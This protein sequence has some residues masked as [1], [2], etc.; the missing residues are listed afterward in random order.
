MTKFIELLNSV[1]NNKYTTI[2]GAGAIAYGVYEIL[3]EEGD[4]QWGIV[5][6]IMGT[7]FLFSKDSDK[8]TKEEVE[9][10]L[11][12]KY[13]YPKNGNMEFRYEE[14]SYFNNHYPNDYPHND[15]EF[16]QF[17]EDNHRPTK[18]KNF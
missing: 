6:I 8:D 11:N 1:K 10:S 2:I 16:E 12:T 18:N 3:T 17:Y 14:P 5:L 13:G 7:G 9:R 15:R 4:T